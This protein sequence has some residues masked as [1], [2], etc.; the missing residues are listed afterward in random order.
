MKSARLVQLVLPVILV[1]A[2]I[3]GC[4]KDSSN[5]TTPPAGTGYVMA[6][7][8]SPDAPTVDLYVD[9]TKVA[10][11]AS[12]LTSTAYLPITEGTHTVDVKLAGTTTTVYTIPAVAASNV[13]YSVFAGGKLA[14]FSFYGFVDTLTTPASGKAH[15]RFIHMAP[16]APAVDVWV[17]G[18]P[19]LVTN[20]SFAEGTSFAPVDAATYS[21]DVRL[22]GTSTSVLTVPNLTF[23]AGKIYTVYAR[24]LVAGTGAQALGA[25]VIV[26]K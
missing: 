10:S 22:T 25:T 11:N 5:P 2:F 8:A 13:Y 6:T 12:Y 7:H 3:S 4:K 19:K 18:G 1:A 24:G 16:D 26:N 15:V 9:G 23:A 21:F 17:V 20:V 14:D